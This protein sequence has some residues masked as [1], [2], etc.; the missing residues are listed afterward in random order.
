MADI[1]LSSEEEHMRNAADGKAVF[2]FNN[3]AAQDG[4]TADTECQGDSREE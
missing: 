4:I 3:E 1:L 2:N